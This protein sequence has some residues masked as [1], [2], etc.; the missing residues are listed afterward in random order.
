MSHSNHE[1]P[2]AAPQTAEARTAG[3]YEH[4]VTAVVRVALQNMAGHYEPIRVAD[5]A[6]LAE[7]QA[8][9]QLTQ[10]Q[11]IPEQP[12]ELDEVAASRAQV[13]RMYET[14]ENA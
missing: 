9:E 12:E 14:L 3:A 10:I 6:V 4:Y 7:A 8:K 1:S 13:T 5:L 2:D 11:R